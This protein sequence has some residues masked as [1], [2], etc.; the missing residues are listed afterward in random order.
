M[1]LLEEVAATVLKWANNLGNTTTGAFSYFGVDNKL[2]EITIIVNV[3]KNFNNII[4][5]KIEHENKEI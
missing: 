2:G 4:R 5:I 1:S 3:N